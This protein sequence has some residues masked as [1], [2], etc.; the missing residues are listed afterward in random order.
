MPSK[1]SLTVKSNIEEHI[2]QIIQQYDTTREQLSEVDSLFLSRKQTL[3]TLVT[4]FEEFI[5]EHEKN[6]P[7]NKE[8]HKTLKLA[9]KYLDQNV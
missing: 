2:T 5:H 9:K 7:K 8:W 6:Y 3:Q 4:G 1:N